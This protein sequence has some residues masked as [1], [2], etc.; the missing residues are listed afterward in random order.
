MIVPLNPH[1]EKGNRGV[2]LYESWFDRDGSL[3]EV[4]S[5]SYLV[6]LSTKLNFL[7]NLPN[8]FCLMLEQTDWHTKFLKNVVSGSVLNKLTRFSWD[9]QKIINVETWCYKNCIM[10]IYNWIVL[11]RIYLNSLIDFNVNTLND[12]HKKINKFVLP[13]K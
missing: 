4:S 3:E 6:Y 5:E 13:V 8:S 9:F 11:L 2:F 10:C 12:M 7:K 1:D